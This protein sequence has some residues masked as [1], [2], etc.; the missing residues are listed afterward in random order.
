M[1][2]LLSKILSR[3]VNDV[4]KKPT[5]EELLNYSPIY[6]RRPWDTNSFQIEELIY[7]LYSPENDKKGQNLVK[8]V[9]EIFTKMGYNAVNNDGY[10]D[11]KKDILVYKTGSDQPYIAIQCKSYTPQS[12]NKRID[13]D[14]VLSFIGATT[15]FENRRIFITTSFYNSNVIKNFSDKVILIDRKG[16]LDLLFKYFPKETANA[17]NVFSLY[18]IDKICQKCKIG[19]LHYVQYKHNDMYHCTNCHA[20]YKPTKND[21]EFKKYEYNK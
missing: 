4:E 5:L 13:Q 9:I 6:K 8:L 1:F 2:K 15:E 10:K 7:K 12:N 11:G 3:K 21:I 14:T 17:L 20:Q 16:L 19:K 18:N